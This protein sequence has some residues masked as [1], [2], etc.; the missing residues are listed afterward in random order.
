MPRSETSELER[1]RERLVKA[2]MGFC[3]AEEMVKEAT[4]RR[5]RL[6]AVHYGGTERV[7]WQEWKDPFD[8]EAETLE[9]LPRSEWCA[10]CREAWE[11]LLDRRFWVHRRGVLRRRMRDAYRSMLLETGRSPPRAGPGRSWPGV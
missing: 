5:S 4:A 6:Y 8:D 3:A 9:A 7:C 11:N 10:E 2:A 1:A